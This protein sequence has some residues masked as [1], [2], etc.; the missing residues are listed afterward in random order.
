ML[1][2]TSPI[3]KI[4]IGGE[5]GLGVAL[6]I[7]ENLMEVVRVGNIGELSSDAYMGGSE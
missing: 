7:K 2:G 1:Q 4:K 3:G 5:R 6:L